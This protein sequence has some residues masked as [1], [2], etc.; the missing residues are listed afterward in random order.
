MLTIHEEYARNM[1]T[2]FS[3]EKWQMEKKKIGVLLINLG[4]PDSY[5]K[6]DVRTYLK[7]FLS[8]ERVIDI[9]ILFRL[10]LLYLIILP[11]RTPKSAKAYQSVWQKGGSPLLVYSQELQLNVEEILPKEKYI[12][13]LAMRYQNPS[14][15]KKV[16]ELIQSNVDEI[17]LFPL[18]PQYSSA[19]SG[20]ALEKAYKEIAKYWNVV[21][22]K[23]IASFYNNSEF[24]RC[25]A[26]R[27]KAI[28]D[29][30]QPDYLLFSYHGLPERHI[31]KS[32]CG[33]K[34]IC[35]QSKECCEIIVNEN[36][37]CYRAQC[38]ATTK[39]IA[40]EL[41]L[42]TNFYSN[43]FQ[44]RLGRTKWIEPYTDIVL[45][46]LAEKGYKKLAIAC[47]AFVADCLETLEEI[48]IRAK[49]Q[50]LD[51]GGQDLI[52]VPSL[53]GDKDW[54]QCVA[55]IILDQ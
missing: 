41:N 18:F 23:T 24:I 16:E 46:Q 51:L 34:K 39:A 7:E 6:K 14:L 13:K 31:L 52:L 29:D 30:F 36:T 43:S 17:I 12:V 4:T 1:V 2:S 27:I 50:W 8:D 37:Y 19:A 35:F 45:P 33:E 3:M 20:S 15:S 44:S 42:P 49:E 54:A 22:V 10:M 5:E 9:P 21:P 11:F 28:L 26:N 55:N 47:P 38:V 32:Q 53:N 25:F 40:N 48:S